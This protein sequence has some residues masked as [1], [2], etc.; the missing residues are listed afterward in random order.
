[1]SQLA[2]DE[3]PEL[4]NLRCGVDRGKAQV[5]QRRHALG[6]NLE[7]EST[8]LVRASLVKSEFPE[9][10][11]NLREPREETQG[12]LLVQRTPEATEGY[13]FRLEERGPTFLDAL[14]HQIHGQAN[15]STLQF[16]REAAYLC[17]EGTKN[18]TPVVADVGQAE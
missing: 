17:A 4:E 11:R 2:I 15:P 6:D 10:R 16:W 1:M 13:A 7:P 12:V 3:V 14:V 8:S 5:L 18:L 9:V